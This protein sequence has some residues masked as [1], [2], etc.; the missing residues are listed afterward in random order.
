MLRVVSIELCLSPTVL[1]WIS[2]NVLLLYRSQQV[3]LSETRRGG[4]IVT[5]NCGGI[6]YT[7]TYESQ[8][9]HFYIRSVYYEIVDWFLFFYY[10]FFLP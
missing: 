10:F 1:L 7:G 3:L 5:L 8:F 6:N 4:K 2:N 9:E